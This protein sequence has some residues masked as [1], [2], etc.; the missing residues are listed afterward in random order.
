MARA[1][2]EPKQLIKTRLRDEMIPIAEQQQRLA[3]EEMACAGPALMRKIRIDAAAKTVFDLLTKAEGMMRWLAQDVIADPR[4][5]GVF[6]LAG[7]GGLW[8]EGVY[9][10][11]VPPDLVA[12]TWGGIEGLK[13]GQSTIKV[14][15]RPDGIGTLVRLD[16]FGL[17]NVAVHLHDLFWKKWGLPKLKAVAEGREPGI[18]CLSEI[19]DWRELYSYST[20]PA[21]DS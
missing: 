19:A 5:G 1:K 20:P 10:D 2:S 8:I 7:F 9:V 18:T 13:P 21:L 3:T 15:V 17:S 6:R 11:V 14:T 16:Q 4:P 12:F